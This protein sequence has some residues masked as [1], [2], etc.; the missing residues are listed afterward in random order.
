VCV[1]DHGVEHG[2]SLLTEGNELEQLGGSLGLVTHEVELHQ[3]VHDDVEEGVPPQLPGSQCALQ[4]GLREPEP[5][6]VEVEHAAGVDEV[7]VLEH[8][9][10][11]AQPAAPRRD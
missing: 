1:A 8:R 2:R 3:E 10:T 6:T 4:V 11:A 5:A 9:S 7:G